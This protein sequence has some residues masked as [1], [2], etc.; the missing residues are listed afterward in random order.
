[1]DKKLVFSVL[2]VVCLLTVVQVV[3]FAQSGGQSVL[4]GR[5][6][7]V[8]GPTR[9]NPE[10]MELLR[11]GT[12]IVDGLGISW[13]AEN[14]RFTLT[15]PLLVTS[16]SYQV[17]DSTLTLTANNGTVLKY[18][19]QSAPVASASDATLLLGIWE[20]D[21]ET[22]TIEFKRNGTGTWDGENM[23]WSINNNRLTVKAFNETVVFYYKIR[24]S[25]LTLTDERGNVYNVLKKK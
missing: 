11:D 19:K 24:G 10:K 15:H 20:D 25:I 17:S 14:G 1:M 21:D 12:G 4:V 3:A 9:N 6:N 2:L 5:W 13:K 23:T 7:L 8:E 18:N 16:W 22:D